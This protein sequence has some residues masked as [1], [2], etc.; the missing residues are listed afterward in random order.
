MNESTSTSHLPHYELAED[1]AA[2]LKRPELRPVRL[3]LELLKPEIIL[4][5][6]GVVEIDPR[7]EK[8]LAELNHAPSARLV[9]VKDGKFT[10][11]KH[12]LPEWV[13]DGFSKWEPKGAQA[14]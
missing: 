14:Q 11:V 5:K 6:S 13:P 12:V 10:L 8:A 3:Q 1:D 9:T 7:D 4:E 2:F